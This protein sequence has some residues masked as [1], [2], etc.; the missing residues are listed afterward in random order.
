MIYYV[1]VAYEGD[2]PRYVGFGKGRRYEH[3]NSGISKSYRLNKAH[4]QGITLRVEF[5]AQ[6]LTKE[7]AEKLEIELIAQHKREDAG[8]TL[9][10]ET[11]GGVGYRAGHTDA[12]RERIRA[13]SKAMWANLTEDQRQAR[14]AQFLKNGE[15][16]RFKK[17]QNSVQH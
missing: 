8:G 9:W 7:E 1:Y 17:G 5:V 13:S 2:V 4:F 15:K 16:T 10:N 14:V 6:G 12:S 3:V 11:N